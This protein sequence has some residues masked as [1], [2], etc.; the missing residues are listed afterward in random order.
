MADIKAALYAVLGRRKLGNPNYEVRP[1]NRGGK[2]RFR[3]EL[4][5]PGINYAG[6]GNS[7]NKKDA[8]TNAA[9]DFGQYLVREGVINASE[10][11]AEFSE[12]DLEATSVNPAGWGN[13]PY[14]PPGQGESNFNSGW[15]KSSY[16]PP[17]QG[18]SNFNAPAPPRMPRMKT[19][20]EQYVEQRAD[21]ISQVYF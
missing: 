2:Q 17:D 7:T 4:R 13:A 5:V 9:R 3:C 8:M 20:H 21:E 12:T 1:E 6:L 11:P 19:M 18:E 16:Q 14:Q 15:G 10:L